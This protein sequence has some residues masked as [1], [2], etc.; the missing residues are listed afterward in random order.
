MA[1]HEKMMRDVYGQTLVE[2]ARADARV[3]VV[4]ADL[5]KSNGTR[6]FVQRKVLAAFLARLKGIR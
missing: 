3:V 2:L 1:L 5:M 6:V 4:E